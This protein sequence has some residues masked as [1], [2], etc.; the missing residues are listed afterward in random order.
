M[1]VVRVAGTTQTQVMLRAVDS[2]EAM[3]LAGTT[4]AATLT[5]RPREPFF[6]S[7]GRWIGFFAG[8]EL[9]KVAT[10]GGPAIA[11]CSTGSTQKRGGTWGADNTIV[12]ATA[13]SRTGLR[14]VP[15]DGGEP[16]V[17]TTPDLANGEM[18]HLFPEMLPGGQAIIFT[19]MMGGSAANAQ[20]AVLDRRTGQR[21]ADPPVD[22]QRC[23]GMGASEQWRLRY[24]SSACADASVNSSPAR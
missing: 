8:N 21:T 12:F 18:F 6:S 13:D 23:G 22:P 3:P 15:S 10:S 19:I 1:R 24:S 5:M 14:E 16:R 7:D 20:V 4:A 11:I 17:L 2:L 9:K